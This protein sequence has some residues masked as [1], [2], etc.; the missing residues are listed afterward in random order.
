MHAKSNNEEIMNGSDTDEIIEGLFESF[1]RKYEENFQEKMKGSDFEFDDVNFLYYDFNKISINRGGSYIDSPKWIKNKRSTINPRNNYYKCFQ[2]AIALALTLDKIK[3]DP[4]GISKIKPFIDQYS[5]SDIDFPSTSKDW[6]KFELNNEI[7]LNILYVLYNT[8]KIHVAYK[9][10]YNLTLEKQV[11]LLMISNG[12]N[13]H[14]LVVKNLPGLLKGITS[15]HKEEFYCLNCFCT[16]STKNK[17]EEHKKVYENNKYC[18][19]EMPNEDNKIIKYNQGEKS[20][21]SPLIIYADLE[22][23]LEKMSICYN[24]SE[25]LSTTEINKHTP[26]GYSLF[27]HCSFDKTK[28][29]LDYYGGKDCMKKFCKNLRERATKII[30]Y[31]KKKMIPLTVKEEKYHNKRKICYICKKEFN[32]NDKKHYKVKDHCHYTGTY[33][34]AAHNICNLRY[35]IPKEIPTVFHNGSTYDTTTIL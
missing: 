28:N 16:Y 12:E 31:E 7:A 26:S 34:G 24:N 3:K 5:W 21:K 4:Q 8:K 20:I 22:C 23:L 29:K 13:W 35:K 18:N 33:R 32:T 30:N 27:T 17:F 11:I 14:Y 25:E 2:Y 10:K 6:K 1:L 19:A 9:S 15:N